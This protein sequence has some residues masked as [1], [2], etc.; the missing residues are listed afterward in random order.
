DQPDHFD[1]IITDMTMPYMTG[2]TL[3]GE[4]LRIR[5]DMPVI[6]CT[7]FIERST[8]IK[9]KALGIQ[10]YVAKPMVIHEL[11]KKVRDALD[12][13]KSKIEK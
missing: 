11:A 4:I 10:E 8:E 6:L 5:P 2:D 12:R 9:A 1:L 7:G 13:G 3:A